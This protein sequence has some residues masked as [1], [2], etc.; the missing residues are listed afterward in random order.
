MRA[1][2]LARSTAGLPTAHVQ[3][4]C[5]AAA[6]LCALTQRRQSGANTHSDAEGRRV[7]RDAARASR[8]LARADSARPSY[9]VVG[10]GQAMCDFSGSVSAQFL[11]ECNIPLGGRRCVHSILNS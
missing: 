7:R 2:G 8:R 6:E 9:D 3:Q 11:Q 1:C 4:D 10:L 5:C